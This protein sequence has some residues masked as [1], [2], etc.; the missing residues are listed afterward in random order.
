MYC[1]VLLIVALECLYKGLFN[2]TNIAKCTLSEEWWSIDVIIVKILTASAVF[3]IHDW[4]LKVQ[5]LGPWSSFQFHASITPV[6]T[7]TSSGFGNAI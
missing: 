1:K 3:Y 2:V 4:I 7:S 6:C 5:N